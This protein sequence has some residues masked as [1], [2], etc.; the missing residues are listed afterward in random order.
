MPVRGKE[1]EH[2]RKRKMLSNGNDKETVVAGGVKV[3]YAYSNH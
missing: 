1:K 2:Q 3:L